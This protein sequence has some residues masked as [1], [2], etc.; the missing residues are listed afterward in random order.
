MCAIVSDSSESESDNEEYT[1]SMILEQGNII[2]EGNSDIENEQENEV[3]APPGT[4]KQNSKKYLQKKKRRAKETYDTA[5]KTA[6]DEIAKSGLN[7]YIKIIYHNDVQVLHD[8]H[9]HCGG[10]RSQAKQVKIQVQEQYTNV[11]I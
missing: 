11:P 5:V 2:G 9:K 7:G 3:D 8:L 6:A 1:N 10:D 4:E